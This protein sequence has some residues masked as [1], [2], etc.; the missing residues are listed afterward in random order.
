MLHPAFASVPLQDRSTGKFLLVNLQSQEQADDPHSFESTILA[1]LRTSLH[2]HKQRRVLKAL[3]RNAVEL[4]AD[5]YAGMVDNVRA[6]L[7]D[8]KRCAL[9]LQVVLDETYDLLGLQESPTIVAEVVRRGD[10]VTYT[11][12]NI[13]L[14]ALGPRIGD[15]TFGAHSP[16]TGALAASKVVWAAERQ[17]C[18]LYLASPLSRL[19]GDKLYEAMD[20]AG[21][22][23]SVIE[24]LQESVAFPDVHALFTT[25][26]LSLGDALRLRLKAGRFR[27]WLQDEAGR[28]RDA[29]I[30]YHHEVAQ[31]AGF[32]RNVRKVLRLASYAAPVVAHQVGVLEGVAYRFVLEV[33]ARYRE[34][35]KPVMFGNWARE[36][37]ERALA[38]RERNFGKVLRIDEPRSDRRLP[39][40]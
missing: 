15:P 31:E 34:G 24:Q 6:D 23:Q 3:R 18:D 37:I 1:K 28:D 13:Q 19:A 25:D 29:V 9:A 27:T 2:S 26:Q 20:A 32:V 35:W 17:N 8:P 16:F 21:K 14:D 38:E 4:K 12:K 36:N 5:Q 10:D 7:E 40:K 22:A 11:W 39:P 33:A 30:A